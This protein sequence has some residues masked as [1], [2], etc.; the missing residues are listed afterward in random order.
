MTSS[1]VLA[2]VEELELCPRY[3]VAYG[4]Q[5]TKTPNLALP[6]R[7]DLTSTARSVAAASAL[8]RL[9]PLAYYVVQAR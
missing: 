2:E 5:N 1:Q 7:D 8:W 9:L 6:R 4:A 3:Q